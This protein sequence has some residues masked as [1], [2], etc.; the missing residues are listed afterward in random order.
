[1][2]RRRI[3]INVRTYSLW[4]NRTGCDDDNL[5]FSNHRRR[6]GRRAPS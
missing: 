3:Q 6:V 1:M 5:Y 2:D 4:S